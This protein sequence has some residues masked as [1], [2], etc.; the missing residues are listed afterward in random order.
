MSGLIEIRSLSEWQS[1]LSSTSVVIADFYADWCGPCKMIAPHFQRLA[2]QHST[3]RKVAFAKVNVDSQSE[4]AQQNKVS[5]MP[6]FKIF[7]NG[8]CIQTIQGADTSALSSAI[9][10]AV[11]LAGS[12]KAPEAIF[13]T[14]GRTLGGESVSSRPT[15][16]FGGLLNLLVSFVGLYVV[17]FFALD[18]QLAA[19][20]SR[21][22][23]AN[24]QRE[25]SALSRG[26]SAGPRADSTSTPGPGPGA[27]AAGGA[28]R[29]QQRAT[30]KTLADL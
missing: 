13:K 16:E 30:F 14:P 1:L 18:G 29:P 21:F 20:N 11:Q 25:R 27:K 7:H 17:S 10:K 12:G 22:N 15:L 9:A 6:T 5:A 23:T 19:E 26:S 4:V 8:S 28:T 2:S 24:A 3:P